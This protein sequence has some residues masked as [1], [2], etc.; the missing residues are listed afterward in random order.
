MNMDN[1][2]PYGQLYDYL[3]VGAGPAGLQLGY[4]LQKAGHRFLLLE[5]ADHA[6]SFYDVL[7][8]H[9]QM[10]SINKRYTGYEHPET[11]LRYDWNSLLCDDSHL[12]MTNYSTRYF[13]HNN[14]YLH[15]LGDFARHYDLPTRY[16]TQVVHITKNEESFLLDDQHGNR[17]RGKRLIMA[18]GIAGTPYYPA[19]PGIKLGTHYLYCSLDPSGYTDQRVLII[20]KGNAAFEMA[21]SLLA[22]ARIIHICSPTSMKLAWE[23]HFMGHVRTVNT[24]FIDTYYLKGQNGLLDARIERL[25]RRPEGIVAYLTYSH[26][27]GQT[28][29][30]VYDRI[31]LCTGFRFDD[32]VFDESCRPAPFRNG[33]LPAMT[34]EWEST[35]VPHLYFAGTLMQMRDFQKTMSSVVHGFRFNILFLSRLLAQKYHGQ[36][37]PYTHLQ[38]DAFELTQQ[39]IMRVSTAAALFLQPDFLGDLLVIDRQ[40]NRAQYYENVSLDYVRSR[41]HEPD[42][43]YYTISL[44]YG[45]YDGNPRHPVRD[46]NPDHASNDIYIH[47][48]IRYYRGNHIVSEQHLAENLENNWRPDHFMFLRTTEI[49]GKVSTQGMLNYGERLQAFLEQRL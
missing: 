7:P 21:N 33:K 40:Q 35:N 22:S 26:A 15:Y 2:N 34:H 36:P 4:F 9:G 13:P 23:T 39:I 45:A 3:I 46:P 49:P 25:E 1:G 20:G 30:L 38:L 29:Q 11:K 14:E 43:E 12:V 8:R 16:S 5:Q 10:I 31:I 44:S 32:T 18:T 6:G 48:I 19:V 37:L 41:Q 47:P 17:Y 24:E 42:E 28:M 27:D